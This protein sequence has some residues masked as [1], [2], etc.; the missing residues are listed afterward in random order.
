MGET[1]STGRWRGPP[2]SG[3]EVPHSARVWNYLL[4]GRDHY[5]ADRV[6]GDAMAAAA[7]GIVDVARTSRYFLHRA[8]RH[9]AGAEGVR[10]F[11][12]IGSGLPTVDNTHEIAQRTAPGSRTVY[13]D[14]DPLVLAHARALL[15]GAPRGAVHHV[16]G[17]V[18]EPEAI[19]T[20]AGR[21]LDLDRPVALLLLGVLGHVPGNREALGLVRRLLRPL[22]SGSFLV[23]YDGTSTSPDMREA[24]RRYNAS[25]AVPYH[26]R[27]P[28]EIAAAFD[29][30]RLLPPG[31]VRC[32]DWRP[33][34]GTDGAPEAP[35][36]VDAYCGI[37]RTP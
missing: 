37:G 33:E 29:G 16:E 24:Q 36:A 3:H 8:V 22:P 18:R 20:G 26:L 1:R 28:A 15:T 31:V 12:D 19:L 32:T 21:S 2:Q 5:A 13:V 9:L 34:F 4:G 30:L 27:T 7:P 6:V 35:A 17:D 10:Q 14:N 25:R 23:Y 11:V